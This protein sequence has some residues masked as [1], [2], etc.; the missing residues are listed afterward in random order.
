M[1]PVHGGDFW[2]HDLDTVDFSANINPLGPSK[3]ALKAIE[4]WKIEF[5]P[6]PYSP[7]LKVEIA[8]YVGVGEDNIT[9]GNGSIEL[10][11]DFCSV[12]VKK[13][14]TALIAGPTFSE[15]ERFF[16]V[17]GG[18]ARYVLA[19]DDNC[20]QHSA[21]DII[22][23]A[24]LTTRIIFI[25][26]PNN[27]TGSVLAEEGLTQVLEFAQERNIYIFLDEA[28]IEFSRGRS[29]VQWVNGWN[30]LFVLRSFTKFYALPG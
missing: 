25:C 2:D 8:G 12:F 23:A 26:R 1:K 29:L 5:Y 27:P 22:G 4:K 24:D 6:P 30:N 11:K 17:Y 21:E 15:Y 13:S 16:T 9:V 7:E 10:V 19:S 3:R 28:F 14:D 20:F 18:R